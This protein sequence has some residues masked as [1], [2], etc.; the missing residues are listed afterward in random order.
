M[1]PCEG[2]GH[3]SNIR[4]LLGRRGF[5][6]DWG[7]WMLGK[8][9]GEFAALCELAFFLFLS[10]SLSSFLPSFLSFSLSLNLFPPLLPSFL[11]FLLF[12]NGRTPWHVEVPGPGIESEPQLRPTLQL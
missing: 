10:F 3:W 12:F 1:W 7:D 5:G 6:L 4:L 2:W 11:F 9:S 8:S